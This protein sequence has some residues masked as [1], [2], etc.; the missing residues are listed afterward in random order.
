[1]TLSRLSVLV[2]AIIGLLATIE[3]MALAEED[4]TTSSFLSDLDYE[5]HGFYEIR[6]GY[7]TRKDHY[8]KDMSIMETRLQ[9][10]LASYID[11]ADLKVKAMCWATL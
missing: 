5:L 8:E 10:D 1:M 11:W 7:R 2:L 6:S 4:E 9:L 3:Q